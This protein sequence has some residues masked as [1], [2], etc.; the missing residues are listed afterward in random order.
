MEARRDCIIK[1][2]QGV[3]VGFLGGLIISL[4]VGFTVTEATANVEIGMEAGL[5][6]QQFA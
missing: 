1:A 3:G 5:C 2:T 6:V 4:V